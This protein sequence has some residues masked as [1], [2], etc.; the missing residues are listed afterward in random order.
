MNDTKNNHFVPQGYLKNFLNDKLSLYKYDLDN[1]LKSYEIT[2]LK[3]ECFCKNL[4]SAKNKITEKEIIFFCQLAG[5]NDEAEIE[6]CKKIADYINGNFSNFIEENCFSGIPFEY[7]TIFKNYL[8]EIVNEK[9]IS[10]T[11][12]NIFTSVYENDFY[13]ILDKIIETKS[14]DFIKSNAN[15]SKI[16]L[17]LYVKLE[18]FLHRSVFNIISK[19]LKE[20]YPD[21]PDTKELEDNLGK[22]KYNTNPYLDLIHYLVIQYFRTEKQINNLKNSL[23]YLKKHWKSQYEDYQLPDYLEKF[24][25]LNEDSFIFIF[26]HLKSIYLVESLISSQYKL[27]LLKNKTEISFITSDS[28][29]I[30]IYASY[31]DPFELQGDDFEIY[32][33]ISPTLALLYT[34][35]IGYKNIKN[36]EI[37]LNDKKAIL[38]F[39]ASI[40]K[41]AKRYLYSNTNNILWI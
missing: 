29:C 8:Q 36:T 9:S 19:K 24:I 12:E 38:Q 15:I 32:F 22:L 14:I 18:A 3:K 20:I 31:I 21:F 25:D 10:R 13:N 23:L 37:T 11:Q 35:R 34:N 16:S 6:F 5:Y 2:N 41:L 7:R 27:L 30:N 17:Y 33:P 26:I 28:P 39:N 4:Y 1:A 40:K